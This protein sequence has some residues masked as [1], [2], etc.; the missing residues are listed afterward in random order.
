MHD[1]PSNIKRKIAKKLLLRLAL[2]HT[3]FTGTQSSQ[4]ENS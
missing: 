3:I 4:L 2:G 1:I